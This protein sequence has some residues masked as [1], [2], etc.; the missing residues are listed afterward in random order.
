M[1]ARA[2]C[3]C[4]F[5]GAVEYTTEQRSG[6]EGELPHDGKQYVDGGGLLS[7]V[8]TTK[9]AIDLNQRFINLQL[10]NVIKCDR[11]LCTSPPRGTVM[12]LRR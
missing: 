2:S 9:C 4:Y 7:S 1:G 6:S 8:T 10:H 12:H 11:I 5:E 3:R